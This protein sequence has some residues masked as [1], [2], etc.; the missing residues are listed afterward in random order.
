M[1]IRDTHM[2]DLNT[3]PNT[4]EIDHPEDFGFTLFKE[5]R[6]VVYLMNELEKQPSIRLGSYPSQQ[7]CYNKLRLGACLS[8]GKTLVTLALIKLGNEPI[9]RNWYSI[10]DRSCNSLSNLNSIAAKV[11]RKYYINTTLIIVSQSVYHQWKKHAETTKVKF[12]GIETNID[13]RSLCILFLNNK[14][15]LEEYD[16]ILMIYKHL[17]HESLPMGAAEH[18]CNYE[19]RTTINV[20]GLL[21]LNTEWKRVVIDDFDTINITQDITIPARMIWCISTT[22]HQITTRHKV[23]PKLTD[24]LSINHK[25]MDIVKDPNLADLT[26]KADLDISTK[27]LPQVK[28]TAY[29]FLRLYLVNKIVND[30]EYSDEVV[31]RINSGDISGAASALGITVHCDTPGEFLSCILEKNK[32]TYYESISTCSRFQRIVFLLQENNVFIEDYTLRTCMVDFYDRV[33]SGTDIQFEQLLNTLVINREDLRHLEMLHS[34]AKANVSRSTHI[35]DRLKRNIEGGECQK[36]LLEPEGA[37]YIVKCCD[38]LL[39]EECMTVSNNTFISR[40]PSC[41]SYIERNSVVEVPEKIS[42]EQFLK[43]DINNAIDD[44]EKYHKEEA[45]AKDP[46][47]EEMTFDPDKN[48]EPKTKALIKIINGEE[49]EAKDISIKMGLKIDG[50]PESETHI[51]RDPET[52]GKYLV[53]VSY[54]K[55]ANELHDQLKV[56]GIESVVLRGSNKSIIK[57]IDTFKN[58]TTVNVMFMYSTA[59]CAGLNLEFATHM[60]FHHSI[61]DKSINKQ[62]IGRAQ[63]LGRKESLELIYLRHKGEKY[64]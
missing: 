37:R 39:C 9:K 25:I 47:E 8:F 19:R 26:I 63:R 2:L 6:Q 51:E 53:F 36:C 24:L 62:L 14:R 49:P 1:P 15:Q 35:L 32:T 57:T 18:L 31:E 5:Q 34:R 38:I 56:R 17:P 27:I 20:L 41:I 4:P 7:I 12:L 23:S 10:Y 64:I 45:T 22:S 46:E 42:L 13:F 33:A 3:N 29:T 61:L 50:V 58:S 55:C 59:Y 11:I 43:Y 21:S 16:V 40:C 48:L 44:I 28:I 52:I 30:M 54:A 60:I